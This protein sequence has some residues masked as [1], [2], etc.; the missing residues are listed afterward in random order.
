MPPIT[1]ES[2][3]TSVGSIMEMTLMDRI[4]RLFHI[5][6]AE[7]LHHGVELAC[8]RA[9]TDHLF[10]HGVEQAALFRRVRKPAPPSSSF[11]A[12]SACCLCFASV[13]TEG[14]S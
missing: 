9:E 7:L 1:T 13:T 12:R 11:A 6:A 3:A 8:L 4:V 10:V 2:T 5:D 14:A